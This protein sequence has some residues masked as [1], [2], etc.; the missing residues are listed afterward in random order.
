MLTSIQ[1]HNLATE[2]AVKATND[3]INQYG[4]TFYC[5]FAWVHIVNGRCK[6]VNDLKKESNILS[7]NW[8][9]SYDVWNPSKHCTQSM[10]AKEVGASAY[11]KVLMDNGI[12]CY[13]ASRAD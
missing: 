12:D 7:K 11:A 9:K 10:D 6:F 1:I 13:M 5:G 8:K 2:S 3:Y 4:E